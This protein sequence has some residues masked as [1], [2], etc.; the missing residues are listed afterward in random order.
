[1]Q[2]SVERGCTCHY[3]DVCMSPFVSRETTPA[4]FCVYLWLRMCVYRM[5]YILKTVCTC[6]CY[7]CCM[8]VSAERCACCVQECPRGVH[9]CLPYVRGLTGLSGVYF[10]YSLDKKVCLKLSEV[11]AKQP[12]SGSRTASLKFQSV[13]IGLSC[14][15]IRDCHNGFCMH[16]RGSN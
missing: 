11:Y 4:F 10:T 14:Y 5:R 15:G 1:M 13:C 16:C 12:L 3:V 9:Q 8:C 6:G 2:G 7:V